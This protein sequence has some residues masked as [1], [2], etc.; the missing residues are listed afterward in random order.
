VTVT[1]AGRS[2]IDEVMS[3]SSYYSHSDL[4]LHFGLGA[5]ATVD[6]VEVRWPCGDREAFE[7]IPANHLIVIEEGKGI[8]RRERL[9]GKA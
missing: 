8:I 4:R 5:A 2:Q 3:G 6:K 1:A 7:S 9:G